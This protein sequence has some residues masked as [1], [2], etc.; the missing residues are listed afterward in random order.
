MKNFV[1]IIILQYGGTEML[2]RCLNSLTKTKYKNYEIIIVDNKSKD[3]SVKF[4]KKNYPNLKLIENDNN[5]G[6]AEGNNIGIKHAN[7]ELVVFMNNDIEVEPDWLGNLIDT[8]KDKKIAACQPKVLSLIDK[9]RF[10][11][12][13]AGGGFID[14]YGYPICRG[15]VYDNIEE[16]K[17]QY[18]DEIDVFWVCGVCM[19]IRK[20]IFI[21]SGGFDKDFFVYG[22]EIDLCW[23][24]NLLGYSLKYV[25]SSVIYHLGRGTSGTKIK[26]WYWLHRNHSIL[27]LK[28]YSL[29]SLLKI[30]PAKLILEAM[31]FFAFLF[32]DYKRSFGIFF[33]WLWVIFHPINVIKRHNQIQRIRKISDKEII[34]KM[35][36]GSTAIEHFIMKKK[37]FQEFVY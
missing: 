19:C 34:K 30:M 5:Y 22:E 32:K 16:D 27:L 31:A 6:F 11:Y 36:K 8:M 1:S 12:A 28:N 21:N 15:R 17:G 2:N 35:L 23:R 37:L 24:L 14:K 4:I 18:N 10:E 26:T 33:G 29:K 3:G 9:Q 13:G 25:P 7:G 20:D